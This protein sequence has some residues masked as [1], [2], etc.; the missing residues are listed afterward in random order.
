MSVRKLI[1]IL[2]ILMIACST[3]KP[4]DDRAD[5]GVDVKE[6]MGP[7]PDLGEVDTGVM[8]A[9]VG[10]DRD[11]GEMM[12]EAGVDAGPPSS[13]PSVYGVTGGGGSAGSTAFKARISIGA[14]SPAGATRS[15]GF[16]AVIG[17]TP[18]TQ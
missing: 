9:D 3:P 10:V 13:S 8:D 16:R 4:P 5:S 12:A 17:T 6:D 11:A 14:P 7:T 18:P 1:F 2:P 15:P